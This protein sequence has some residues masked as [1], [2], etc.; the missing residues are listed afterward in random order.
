MTPNILAQA[1]ARICDQAR[2][3]PCSWS[4][5]AH[6]TPAQ[7]G[8]AAQVAAARSAAGARLNQRLV[9]ARPCVVSRPASCASAPQRP[10]RGGE[11][12]G[13]AADLTGLLRAEATALMLRSMGYSRLT[14]WGLTAGPTASFSMYMHGPGSNRDPLSAMAMTDT[15]PLRPCPHR[16]ASGFVAACL[17]RR[18]ARAT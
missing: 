10:G 3:V 15:A 4:T 16:D 13:G 8:P 5:T 7:T 14:M 9:R 17:L 1:E 2:P 12:Q 11:V 6:W 18:P